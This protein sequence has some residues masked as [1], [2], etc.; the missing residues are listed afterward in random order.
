MPVM[1]GRNRLRR[2]GLADGFSGGFDVI[3]SDDQ[4][5]VRGDVAQVDVDVGIGQLPEEPACGLRTL[6]EV[7]HQHLPVAAHDIPRPAKHGLSLIVVIGDQVDRINI[8]GVQGARA[9]PTEANNVDAGATEY[10]AQLR[11]R[12]R[13]ILEAHCD[14]SR[15]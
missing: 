3:D 6:T 4:A 12:T 14:I 15:Q 2:P 9:D 5:A 13:A 1:G 7:F 10:R 11:K 8:L